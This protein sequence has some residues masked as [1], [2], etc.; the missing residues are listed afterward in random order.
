MVEKRKMTTEVKPDNPY[1]RLMALKR[2]G[3]V[4]NFEEIRQFSVLIVGIGGVGSVVAEMLTRCGIGKL[5]LY[6]YDKV[7]LANMNRMFYLP[8]HDG[9]AK[10]EAARISLSA[11]NPDVEIQTFNANICELEHY[12]KFINNI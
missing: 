12:H 3:V 1:S 8:S 10:V 2:M 11:I 6:D 9:L 4:D 5:I 7:E